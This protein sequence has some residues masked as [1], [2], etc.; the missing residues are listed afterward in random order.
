MKKD[1][2]TLIECLLALGITLTFTLLV[3]TVLST[4]RSEL[5]NESK[6]DQLD[7]ER[8]STTLFGDNLELQHVAD[9]SVSLFYSPVT[10]KSYHLVFDGS[11]NLLK[12]VATEG[13]YLPLLY[14]VENYQIDYAAGYLKITATIHQKKYHLVRY[15][16][17]KNEN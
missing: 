2:F 4:A 6:V 8:F 13:G 17:T 14:D 1:A 7:W 12:L 16:L 11:K 9:Q 15:I 3:G 5:F 10:N